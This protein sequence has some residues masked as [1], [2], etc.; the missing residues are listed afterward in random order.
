MKLLKDEPE[1]ATA[2]RGQKS[3]G[4]AGDFTLAQHDPPRGR[5]RH[6]AEDTQQGGL[7]RP[8]GTFQCGDPVRVD[9]Q[10]DTVDGDKLVDLAG[11]EDLSDVDELDHTTL[12]PHPLI[13]ESGSMMAARQEGTMVATV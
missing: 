4:K 5:A 9:H 8:A 13:T 3:F 10:T 11:V 2:H 1:G 7:A 6:A 12:I